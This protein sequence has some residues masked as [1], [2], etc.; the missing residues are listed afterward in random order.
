M[1]TKVRN[2]RRLEA[3]RAT[4]YKAV[5]RPTRWGNPF[6]ITDSCPRAESMRR[7]EAW[8]REQLA[9]D[10]EFLE[11]LRGYH[12]GCFCAPDDACHA[13]ILLRWL[14]A[15]DKQHPR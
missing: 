4:N 13:D 3:R 12:L 14:Y 11:P 9:R 10:P 6:P 15:P 7:Y 8:L 2:P 1:P 5:H